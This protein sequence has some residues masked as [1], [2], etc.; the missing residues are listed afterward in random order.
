MGPPPGDMGPG[1]DGPMGPPPGAEGGPMGPPPGE[2]GPPPGD[3][4][5][6]PGPDGPWDLQEIWD[7]DLMDQWDLLQGDMGPGGP[8]PGDMG[9]DLMDQWDLLQEIWDQTDLLRRYGTRRT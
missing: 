5:G 8:P 2:G 4:A 1:P 7:R 6:G 9:P 3:M